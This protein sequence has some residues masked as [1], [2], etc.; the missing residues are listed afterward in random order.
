MTIWHSS[1]SLFGQTSHATTLSRGILA[2]AI[3]AAGPASLMVVSYVDG[4]TAPVA[5][6]RGSPIIRPTV[7]PS[8]EDPHAAV[9]A[10]SAQPS[11]P[12]FSDTR[13][14]LGFL[15]FEDDADAP[16]R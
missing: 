6:I 8:A 1:A 2:L 15:E 16:R 9:A 11:S 12:E 4:A 14:R 10:S 13:F 7:P 3:M 5:P